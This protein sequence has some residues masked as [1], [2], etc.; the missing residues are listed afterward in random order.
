MK[1]VILDR[2][3]EF[4]NLLPITELLML[5]KAIYKNLLATDGRRCKVFNIEFN[6]HEN[7]T[8]FYIE[9][10]I[11]YK[12]SGEAFND[13]LNDL[14][15]FGEEIFVFYP[16]LNN[17]LFSKIELAEIK[18]HYEFFSD[19]FKEI[20]DEGILNLYDNILDEHKDSKI[21]KE[22]MEILELDDTE[23]N[24]KSFLDEKAKE[25]LFIELMEERNSKK[26]L[27]NKK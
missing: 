16:T 1:N 12:L 2:K 17:K 14:N 5:Y 25:L 23:E 19:S 22:E 13:Y 9:S 6:V 8:L 26:S 15:E 4:R 24:V 27:R 7:P 11:R 18:I 10:C 21:F 20:L 3:Y